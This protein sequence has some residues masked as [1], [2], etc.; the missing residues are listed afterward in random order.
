[1]KKYI[2]ITVAFLF[3][4]AVISAIGFKIF[5]YSA[6]RTVAGASNVLEIF[7]I[8]EGQGVKSIGKNLESAGL[9]KNKNYFYYYVWKKNIG[10]KLQAGKYELA[11]NMTIPQIA[12]KF[13]QGLIKPEIKKI[14]IPEGFTNKKIIERLRSNAPEMADRFAELANCKCLNQADCACDIFSQR[15]Y[16]LKLIPSGVDMEGYLFPDTYFIEKDDTPEILMEK[17]LN[18]FAKHISEDDLAMI[19]SQNRNLFQII[20][21]ASIIEREVKTDVDRKIASGLF[22]KRIEDSAPLQSCA[23]LAYFLG[24]DKPQFSFEDT[25]VESPYNTYINP[26]LPPGPIANPGEASIK[27]AIYPEQT[28]YYYFLSDPETGA[29]IY[30]KTLEEHNQNKL[31][32][33]L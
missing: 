27:A 5:D 19:E 33:G 3:F 30:S 31:K 8:E 29:I 25:R 14:T 20:T 11:K 7:E 1:M 26:G 17:F 4:L 24:I 16:F 6:N 32:Y 18:N 21:M 23:T 12:E 2:F 10:S 13:T 15:F 28:D 9:I 22:W